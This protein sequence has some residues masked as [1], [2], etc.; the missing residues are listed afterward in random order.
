MTLDAAVFQRHGTDLIDYVRS[1]PS[2]PWRATNVRT[3]DT[4]GFE[5]TVSLDA[6]RVART[7]LTRLALRAAFYSADLEALQAS[8]GASEGRYVLDPLRV[9]CDLLAEA[10]LPFRL[11]AM[12]R[13]SYFDRPS[14]PDGVLLLD[15]RLGYDLL[16]GDILEVYLE[17]SNLGDVR[18]EEVPGVP[19]PGITLAAGARLTW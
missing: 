1:S 8:A 4:L 10:R 13:L 3:A 9:R 19:L 12:A 14:L 15:A 17:G 11:D 18:Y 2:E 6:S 7:P 16:E 5:G